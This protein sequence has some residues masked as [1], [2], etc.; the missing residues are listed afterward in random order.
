MAAPS[1]LSC[2]HCGA[3]LPATDPHFCVECGRPLG[4]SAATQRLEEPPTSPSSAGRPTVRLSNASVPQSVLGGTMRLATTGAIPPGMWFLE[5]PPGPE[6]V[7]AVYAPLRAV[8]GGWSGQIGAG[9]RPLTGEPLQGSGRAT[10]AFETSRVWFAA[11]G[12]AQGLHLR[13]QIRAQAEADLG[14][15]RRGFRYRSHYDPP[16]WIA[17]AWWC[18]PRSGARHSAPV[19]RIQ[20]M[21]PPR[22][23]RV[24]DFDEEIRSLPAEQAAAQARLGRLPDPCVLLRPRQQ[25]TPAGRGLLLGVERVS[26]LRRLFAAPAPRFYVQ[27][28]TPLVCA[29]RAWQELRPRI[30]AEAQG[31]GLDMESDA[32][33]EWWLDRQGHDSLVLQGWPDQPSYTD[34]VIAFRRQQII[35]VLKP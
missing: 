16:M 10:F 20:L 26:L 29:W 11:P 22:I 2:P 33:V 1:P 7:V 32:V 31:Y 8:V 25:R 18:E 13:V 12:A 21:A 14:R 4:E 24:S 23:P 27:I 34:V 35:A 6:D 28:Q 5:Q 9:W 3:Q 15:T 30:Q 19:P 17:D